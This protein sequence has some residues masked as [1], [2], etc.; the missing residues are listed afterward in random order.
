[1]KFIIMN[2]NNALANCTWKYNKAH[3]TTIKLFKGTFYLGLT[4][5]LS[6]HVAVYAYIS[7]KSV[8]LDLSINT[9]HELNFCENLTF[10]WE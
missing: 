7:C 5:L 1:M 9:I 6:F 4:F 3:K 2:E 10:L 8:Y